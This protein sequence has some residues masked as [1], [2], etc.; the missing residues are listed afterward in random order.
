MKNAIIINLFGAP[1]SGKST[2]ASELFAHLKKLNYNVE[3]IQEFVKQK[4]WN[5][6]L[7]CRSE[8]YLT[9][10]FL[11]QIELLE[12][13]VDVIVLDSSL[14]SGVL[15]GKFK[16]ETERDYFTKLVLEIFNRKQNLNFVIH[17]KHDYKTEGRLQTENEAIAFERLLYYNLGVLDV[18]YTTVEHTLNDIKK[19]ETILNT[20]LNY[21]RL[22]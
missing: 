14:L 10:N 21:E 6:P 8:L 3:Y 15:F 13:K 1:C 17:R 4:V 11:Y 20:K 7:A 12:D 22:R 2:F 16:T 19:V 18:R 9:G 5:D